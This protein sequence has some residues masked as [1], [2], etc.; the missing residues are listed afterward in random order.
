MV[1]GQH[2][3]LSWLSNVGLR[4]AG[5]ASILCPQIL[6]LLYT[7]HLSMNDRYKY[8][9]LSHCQ[10]NSGPVSILVSEFHHS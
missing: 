4:E 8:E 6:N 7:Y 2:D 3:I 1:G 9:I 5:L 10:C